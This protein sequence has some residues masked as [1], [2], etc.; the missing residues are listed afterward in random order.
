MRRLI[1]TLV[2]VLAACA[3]AGLAQAQDKPSPS[4]MLE[5]AFIAARLCE[6]VE[7][8]PVLVST[9][10]MTR[11]GLTKA[12]VEQAADPALVEQQL[13]DQLGFHT[14]I[15]AGPA[16][17]CEA[18]VA[19]YGPGGAVEP[20]LVVRD[21]IYPL[22]RYC[23][24]TS[25]ERDTTAQDSWNW[26]FH[27]LCDAEVR[28]AIHGPRSDGTI[29]EKLDF[30]IAPL[31]YTTITFPT[32]D[33]EGFKAYHQVHYVQ[34][35][36][37]DETCGT[38]SIPEECMIAVARGQVQSDIFAAADDPGFTELRAR[39]ILVED[40]AAAQSIIAALDAGEAFAELAQKH[41]IGPSAANGGDLGWFGRGQMVEPFEEA[42]FALSPGE[43]SGPVE[44]KFGWHVILLEEAR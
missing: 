38:S 4:E 24:E 20:L 9:G 28:A 6:N 25:T 1:S 23:V 39:H 29:G 3:S 44:T 30:L 26:H 16:D 31:D 12:G 17:V 7:A 18:L 32:P 42:V 14:L 10:F 2:S 15:G 41:S 36:L 13:L 37:F 5:S 33:I 11:H 40:E 27:N 22:A 19:D 34:R 35:S 43:H 21:D 8:S